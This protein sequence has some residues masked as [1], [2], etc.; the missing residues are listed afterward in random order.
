MEGKEHKRSIVETVI[1]AMNE[2]Y[3]SKTKDEVIQD[4]VARTGLSVKRARMYYCTQVREGL[5]KGVSPKTIIGTV[6]G[7]MTTNST[8]TPDSVL[9][10][11]ETACG[12]DRRRARLYYNEAILTKGVKGTVLDG[13]GKGKKDSKPAAAARKPTDE[14][15]DLSALNAEIKAKNLKTIKTVAEKFNAAHGITR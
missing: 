7:I 14:V 11:I 9:G 1:E 13:P 2:G 12:I 15:A 4:I 8:G 6:V 5:A 3:E 10:L